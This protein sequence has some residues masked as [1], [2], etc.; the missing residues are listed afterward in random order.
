MKTLLRI[1]CSSRTKGSHSRALADY[2]E[3]NWKVAN[4]KGVILYRDLVKHQL[5][6]IQNNTIEGFYTPIEHMTLENKRATALSDELIVEL[7]SADDILI[8]SPLYNLNIPSNLKAYLDQVVRIGYTFNINENGYY[9]LL[10]NKLAYLVTVKGGVYKGTFMEQYDFQ[11]PYLKTILGH[12][13]IK[14]QEIFSL[15]GSS[16]KQTLK[17]NKNM[18][19]KTIN[20]SFKKQIKT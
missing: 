19:E 16:E 11:E 2:F 20:Q 6:H 18:L 14:V 10:E 17:L 12:M 1:D 3:K 13:G 8:S 4:P 7:K 5:P 15:E 9:G